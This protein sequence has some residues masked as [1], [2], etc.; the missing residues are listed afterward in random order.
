MIIKNIKGE[1]KIIKEP[2][3][4]IGLSCINCD[5]RASEKHHMIPGRAYRHKCEIFGLTIAL[6]QRCHYLVHNKP[7]EKGLYRFYKKMAQEMFEKH[8]GSHEDWM[9]LFNQNYL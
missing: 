6:C 8:I 4:L 1:Y 9:I 3:N 2:K 5:G 7:K